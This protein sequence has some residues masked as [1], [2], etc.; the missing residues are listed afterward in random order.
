M[1]APHASRIMRSVCVVSLSVLLASATI[2][3]P[4]GRVP[5]A[6]AASKKTDPREIEAR[7]A[8]AA[9]RYQEALD[10]YA[11]LFADKLHPTY[12]RNIGR[13]Y[14]NLR[15]PDQAIN[16]FR[17]YLRQAKDMSAAERVEI[18]GYIAE[19]EALKKDQDKA[20]ARA[21][22]PSPPASP[23]PAAHPAS[24]AIPNAANGA[25][26]ATP[27]GVAPANLLQAPSTPPAP[28]RPAPFYA[29]GWFWGVVGGAVVL[30]VAGGLW[31]GGV[32]SKSTSHCP[33]G[34]ICPP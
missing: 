14:Q 11:A 6:R 1:H 13:C 7:H 20:K 25:P 23:Q 17:D 16:A 31:A 8:F 9:G 28:A 26:G 33:A 27:A 34:A 3:A 12:L 24:A 10:L 21:A 2:I 19:M 32:F 4:L 29:R 15:Q 22:N 30:G 18:D 5:A